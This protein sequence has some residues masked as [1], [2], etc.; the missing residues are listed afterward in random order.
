MEKAPVIIGLTRDVKR[1]N[2]AS[3]SFFLTN[4]EGELP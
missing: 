4:S 2:Y 3:E 1:L